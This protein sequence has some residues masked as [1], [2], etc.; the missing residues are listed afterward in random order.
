M[1][2][3]ERG[4]GCCGWKTLASN[5]RGI[6]VVPKHR[7]PLVESGGGGASLKGGFFAKVVNRGKRELGEVVWIQG[8]LDLWS[9][10]VGCFRDEACVTEL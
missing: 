9:P 8:A 10:N 7:C 4:G 5:S 2:S 6:G 1:T 3:G